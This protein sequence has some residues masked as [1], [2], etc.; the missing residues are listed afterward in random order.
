LP[1]KPALEGVGSEGIDLDRDDV[2]RGLGEDARKRSFAG[3]DLERGV[4]GSKARRV[5]DPARRLGSGQEVLSPALS[6]RD[7]SMPRRRSM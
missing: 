2:P 5:G 4:F 6:R 1:N 7:H 3:T